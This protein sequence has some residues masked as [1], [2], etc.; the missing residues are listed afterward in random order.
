MFFLISINFHPFKFYLTIKGIFQ[1]FNKR[2][3]R[4]YTD[5]NEVIK[6]YIPQDEIKNLIQEDLPF[7]KAE[8]KSD[9]KIKFKLPRL[10]LLDKIDINEKVKRTKM[11]IRIRNF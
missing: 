8:N 9:N 1:I 7:I 10:D 6:E 5:K 4:N 2:Y 3:Q 11:K